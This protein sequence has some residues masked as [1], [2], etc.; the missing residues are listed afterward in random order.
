MVATI[1]DALAL[2]NQ[3]FRSVTDKDGEPYA[4]HCLRVMMGV[5]DPLAQQVALMHDLVEDTPVT[6]D[7]LRERG[8]SPEVVEA[9]DL[10]THKPGDSYAEY[11]VR[12]KP[13]RLA[14]AVKMSDLRDNAS[15][16]RALLREDQKE[17]DLKRMQRYILSY[18]FLSDRLSEAA[19]RRQMQ[20]LEE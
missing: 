17:R 8:F 1:D 9:V 6:L 5:D 10:V 12:I 3:H 14:R 7:E 2:V 11:V 4:M 16:S 15:L 19:Y 13:H 18:Q 20:P